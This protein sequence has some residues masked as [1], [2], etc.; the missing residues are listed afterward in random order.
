MTSEVLTVAG[1]AALEGQGDRYWEQVMALGLPDYLCSANG[2]EL[3]SVL[4]NVDFEP[5]AII[6]AA[7][8][9]C[10]ANSKLHEFTARML[11]IPQFLLEK[12]GDNARGH[13]TYVTYFKALV[14]ELEEWLGE[15]LD[16]DYLRMMLERCN[17]ASDL[18]YELMEMRGHRP[19]PCPNLFTLFAY[20][21]RFTMWGTEEAITMMQVMVDVV[22]ERLEKGEYPSPDG[23]IARCFWTYTYYY[24]DWVRFFNNMEEK[25]ITFVGDLLGSLIMQRYDTTDMDTMFDGL[26][27]NC[28][29]YCMTR[30]MGAESMSAQWIDDLIHWTTRLDADAAIFCGHH[31]CK[32][33]WS[34]FSMTRNELMKRKK[35]PTL[36]LQ[37]DAWL[38]TMTPMSAIEDQ[39]DEFVRNV[40]VK[41]KTGKA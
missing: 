15:K 37:G 11:G 34:V 9:S 22:R 5:D 28:Q 17:K 36:M 16:E 32:Q 1:A 25:G 27:R 38:K 21:A 2:V 26:A 30:Q 29:D 3:G 41:R 14:G 33:T 40:V 18:F 13:E 8:G 12:P 31:A 39:I 7:P 35:I 19:S 24:W 20:A 23:E 10:D 6:S 4:T